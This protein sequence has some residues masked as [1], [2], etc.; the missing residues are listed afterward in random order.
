MWIFVKCLI[1]NPTFDSQTKENLTLKATSFGSSCNPSD[2][3]F[4]NLLKCGIVDYIME[5]V[6][7]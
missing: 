2:A 3:F 6:N 4:K 1:E 5:D 7:L